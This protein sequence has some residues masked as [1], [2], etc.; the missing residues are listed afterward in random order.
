[1]ELKSS[2]YKIK[3]RIWYFYVSFVKCEHE[4]LRGMLRLS[5]IKTLLSIA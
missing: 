5:Q 3:Q 2:P 1:M 4:N